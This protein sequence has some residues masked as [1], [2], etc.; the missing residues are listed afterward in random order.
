M[1]WVAVLVKNNSYYDNTNKDRTGTRGPGS[2][3]FPAYQANCQLITANY[4]T[5]ISKQS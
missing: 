2:S 4:F 3:Y 5:P 1:A